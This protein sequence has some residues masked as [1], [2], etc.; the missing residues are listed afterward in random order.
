MKELKTAVELV[1]SQCV[2]VLMSQKTDT[3]PKNF[4]KHRSAVI[5]LVLDLQQQIC[6]NVETNEYLIS[7]SLLTNWPTSDQLCPQDNKN[8]FPIEN[9]CRVNASSQT[10]HSQL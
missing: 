10:I 4:C 9:V 6:P 5:R 7:P 1:H 2:I 8:L 3:R